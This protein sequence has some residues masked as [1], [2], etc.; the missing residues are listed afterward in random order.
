MAIEI[1]EKKKLD[2][3]FSILNSL[4]PADMRRL[5]SDYTKLK[6]SLTARIAVIEGTVDPDLLQWKKVLLNQIIDIADRT[7]MIYRL[8]RRAGHGDFAV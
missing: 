5:A 1:L 4:S 7:D 6:R 2:A 8:L 3:Q